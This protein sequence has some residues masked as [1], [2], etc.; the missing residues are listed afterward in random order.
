MS[1]TVYISLASLVHDQFERVNP[2][3]YRA[4]QERIRSMMSPKCIENRRKRAGSKIILRE[5]I[6]NR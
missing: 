6:I 4:A 1:N 2:E 3:N 5:K